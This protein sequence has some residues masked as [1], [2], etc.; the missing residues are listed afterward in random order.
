MGQ[1]TVHANLFQL[2]RVEKATDG[3]THGYPVFLSFI[4]DNPVSTGLS[5]VT[6]N[7]RL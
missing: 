5:P 6:T 7:A 2:E 3:E 4:P 1:I